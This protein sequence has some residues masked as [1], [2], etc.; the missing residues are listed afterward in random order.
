VFTNPINATIGGKDHFT[1]LESVPVRV[2]TTIAP[3]RLV[4]GVDHR[5]ICKERHCSHKNPNYPIVTTCMNNITVDLAKSNNLKLLGVSTDVQFNI[6]PGKTLT[7][8][9]TNGIVQL[10]CDPADALVIG[11]G[12]MLFYAYE[13]SE[14]TYE[15]HPSQHSVRIIVQ[16]ALYINIGEFFKTNTD[17][18]HYEMSRLEYAQYRQRI[19]VVRGFNDNIITV[20]LSILQ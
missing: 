18:E 8:V 14:I 2:A 3:M 10:L 9:E 19:G 15:D 16:K 20:Q 17:K 5:A 12:D 13:Q 4:F 11:I 6:T 1:H 7:S